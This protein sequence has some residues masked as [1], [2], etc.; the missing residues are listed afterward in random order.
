MWNGVIVS[1][2]IAFLC[3]HSAGSS[4]SFE[5]LY[6]MNMYTVIV[7]DC[8]RLWNDLDT[9]ANVAMNEES[10]NSEVI[11]RL[12]AHTIYIFDA[13]EALL[14]Q[15]QS[16]EHLKSQLHHVA[17]AVEWCLAYTQVFVEQTQKRHVA[18][19]HKYMLL[20]KLLIEKNS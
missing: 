20:L 17:H 9:I 2:L 11:D 1:S 5:V 19:L 18:I 3:I 8:M 10:F 13:L 7:Q 16:N 4:L 6:P 12:V 15:E 14:S